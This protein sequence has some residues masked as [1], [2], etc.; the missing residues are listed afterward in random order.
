VAKPLIWFVNI[1]VSAILRLLRIKTGARAAE[2]R[3]SPEAALHRARRRQL[4]PAEAQE[5]PAEPVRPGKDLGGRRHDA[6]RP[7]RGPEPGRA[8]GRDP[9]P[10]GHLLSQQAAG[11]EGE[12]NHIVGILHVRKTVSLF[13]QE[14][15][16][17]HDDIRA[18]LSAPY[19]VPVETDVFTQLQYFQ[20]N[21]ERLGIVVD[22]YGEVQGLVTLEDIIEEMIGE[23]TTS[24]PGSSGEGF[25][26]DKDGSCLLEGSTTLRDIN[27]RLGLKLPLDGPKTINGLLLETLQDIPEASVAVKIDGCVIE[28]V[29]VQNQA[30]RM[31]KLIAAAAV[32]AQGLRRPCPGIELHRFCPR[33]RAAR[34]SGGRRAWETCPPCALPAAAPCARSPCCTLPTRPWPMMMFPWCACCTS[35]WPMRSA[36][37]RPTC[38]SNP[39]NISSAC[40]CA[41]M[42]CCTSWR[43]RR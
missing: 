34:F 30:I 40:A 2:Q 32:K 19:Y 27:K 16:I 31:V 38:I 17:S 36:W 39:S 42:A 20:E 11:L 24:S 37:A 22:E 1:F 10:A 26:W 13:R 29:Q 33:K 21:H 3:I 15:E 12:I 8:G 23:F 41:W 4:H 14:D 18:L 25:G 35:C 9:A 28:I 7:G 5:H 6:A 43:S